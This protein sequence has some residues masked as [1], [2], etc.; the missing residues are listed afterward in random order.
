LLA[1]RAGHA[2]S[3]P[4]V[5][6]E[7]TP[8]DITVTK[9]LKSGAVHDGDPVTFAVASDVLST[10]EPHTLFVAKGAIAMGRII[11][12][13]K[14]TMLGGPGDLQ[15]SCDYCLGVD[16][17]RVYLRGGQCIGGK[18]KSNSTATIAAVV[19]VGA[20]GLLI[21]GRDS[22]VAQGTTYRMF[23]DQEATLK[24]SPPSNL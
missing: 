18:G 13:K 16:G 24:P 2:A 12:S 5:L 15:F 7:G 4:I 9:T 8:I 19:L 17:R 14:K 10:S 23:V 22:S 1:A 11:L 3:D 20:S 21:S 6:A